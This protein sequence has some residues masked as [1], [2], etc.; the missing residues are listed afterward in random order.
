MRRD[1]LRA[2]YHAYIDCLN[3]RSLDHLNEFVDESVEY[4]GIK[5]SLSG[6]RTMLESDFQ[7][8]PDLKF[9]IG[10]LC[11]D[12]PVISSRLD[13]DCS[14]TGTLFGIAVNGKRVQFRENVFYEYE[15]NLIRRVWSLIDTTT[16]AT[17]IAA[18]T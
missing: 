1:E 9:N 14:P 18:N 6:Y 5:I 7:A 13:F 4:N 3:S 10:L 16:I 2:L 8:I 15:N 12:P 11:S 17:Q